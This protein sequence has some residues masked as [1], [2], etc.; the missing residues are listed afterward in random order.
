MSRLGCVSKGDSTLTRLWWRQ[1]C[2]CRASPTI[3][4]AVEAWVGEIPLA[5]VPKSLNGCPPRGVNGGVVSRVASAARG[6]AR[7]VDAAGAIDLIDGRLVGYV[8]TGAWGVGGEAGDGSDS[9]TLVIDGDRCRDMP[10]CIVAHKSANAIIEK[11]RA[12]TNAQ[13][14]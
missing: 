4:A 13:W 1:A 6:P 9:A 3:P 11:I 5:V 7:I 10:L 12:K 8:K 2:R 14:D